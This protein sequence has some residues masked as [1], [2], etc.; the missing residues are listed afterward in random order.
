M[1]SDDVGQSLLNAHIVSMRSLG[2]CEEK[3]SG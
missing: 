1:G 3:S 2:I